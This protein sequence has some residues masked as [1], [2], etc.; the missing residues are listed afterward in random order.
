M[1]NCQPLR[2]AVQDFLVD[3]CGGSR[4]EYT[5]VAALVVVVGLLILLAVRKL[6]VPT[7]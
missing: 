4:M 7:V 3:D 2:A 1:Q 6:T 5:L